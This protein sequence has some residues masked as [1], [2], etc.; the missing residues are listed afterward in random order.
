MTTAIIVGLVIIVVI[1]LIFVPRNTHRNATVIN[2]NDEMDYVR[3]PNG[4]LVA[5]Y[6]NYVYTSAGVFLV[7]SKG[8]GLRKGHTYTVKTLDGAV[9]NATEENK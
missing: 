5:V 1:A 6:R 3:S 2:F 4:S 7:D 8:S 9:V